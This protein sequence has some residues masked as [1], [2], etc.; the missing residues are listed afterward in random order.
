MD[1]VASMTAFVKVVDCRGFSAAAQRMNLS[2]TMISN[3]VRAL[4]EKL[5]A[6][7]LNRTT[8]KLSLTEVGRIYYE[9]CLQILGEIDEADRLAVA[10]QSVPRGI[11]RLNTSTAIAPFL[12][13]TTAAFT[14]RY[15][16]CSIILTMTDRMV[17][18]VEEGFDLAVRITQAGDSSLIV[19]HLTSYRFVVCG[20]PR[21]LKAHGTP[22][23]LTDL[24]QH[25][26][27]TYSHSPWG[28]EWH[29]IGTDGEQ[30]VPVSGNLQ[31]NS[32]ETLRA[33]AVCA[34]GLI[35]VPRFLVEQDIKAGRLMPIL[36]KFLPVEFAID[37]YYPHRHLVSAKVRSFIDLLVQ[38]FREGR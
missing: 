12:A 9:R 31:T 37:A 20:A 21:Y 8:R 23:Q 5:G 3:H 34:Q 33:A 19:R 38:N 7:L 25:N 32:A 26:C 6:R 24:A 29:F 27:L 16:E 10:Q 15:P 36:A 14:A 17:D 35:F 30:P 18:M 28:N 22:R 2:P 13:P 1:R 4:E 11:L